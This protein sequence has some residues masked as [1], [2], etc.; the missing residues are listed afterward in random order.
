MGL[1]EAMFENIA[2][3]T[4]AKGAWEILQNNFKGVDKV[5]KV[6]LQTLRGEFES[7]HMKETEY[8]PNYGAKLE[9]ACVNEKYKDR[10]IQNCNLLA[11][12]LK[13]EMIRKPWP[14]I[15]SLVHYK[16]IQKY[17]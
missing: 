10:W 8:I 15:N 5:K 13:N 16:H 12:P 7:L 11:Y 3:A 17:C 14:L 6:R 4:K 1:D 9:D 2:S